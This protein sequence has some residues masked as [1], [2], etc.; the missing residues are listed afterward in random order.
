MIKFQVRED[1]T[2]DRGCGDPQCDGTCETCT[3]WAAWRSQDR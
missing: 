2:A 3:D 1:T